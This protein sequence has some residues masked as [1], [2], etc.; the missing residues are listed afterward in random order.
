[1][2]EIKLTYE[3]E[4]GALKTKD[5]AIV[6]RGAE[7]AVFALPYEAHDPVMF[8]GSMEECVEAVAEVE[9]EL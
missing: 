8:S 7:F 3:V 9:L 6:R 5:H 4:T 1:M 2:N